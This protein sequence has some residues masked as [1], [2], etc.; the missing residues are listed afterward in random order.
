ME[1][2]MRSHAKGSRISRRQIL[3]LAGLAPAAAFVSRSG[4]SL[5]AFAATS[6][7]RPIAGYNPAWLPDAAQ[8]QRWLKQLHDFGPIRAAGTHQARAFEEWLATQVSG[9]GFSVERDQYKL[10]S[11]E[12]D[13]AKDC[14]IS[15]AEDAGAKKNVEVIAYYPFCG[16]TRGKSPVTGRVVYIPN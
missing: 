8:L 9:L 10:T 13:V 2:D 11:W 12:C 3:R 1:L 14:A 16:S 6:G 5:E 15:V 4:L 7:G